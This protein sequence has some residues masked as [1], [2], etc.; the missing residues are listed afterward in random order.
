MCVSQEVVDVSLMT[1]VAGCHT[2]GS[3][4]GCVPVI[5]HEH[6]KF[7]SCTLCNLII[8]IFRNLIH[9]SYQYLNN[10]I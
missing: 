7:F 2:V 3:L 10:F 5:N 1:Q 6:S 9:V 4:A 8:N